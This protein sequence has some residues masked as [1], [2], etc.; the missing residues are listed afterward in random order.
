MTSIKHIINSIKLN[1]PRLWES[2]F[3]LQ[4]CPERLDHHPEGNTFDHTMIVL[5]RAI[6]T[7]NSV[8]IASAIFHDLG[9]LV[10]Y[11]NRGFQ[12]DVEVHSY[13]SHEYAS[14]GFVYTHRAFIDKFFNIYARDVEKIVRNHMRIKSYLDGSMKKRS[15]KTE[16]ENLSVFDELKLFAKLDDMSTPFMGVD[17]SLSVK[18]ARQLVQFC[19][20][21][22]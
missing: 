16:L 1:E 18:Q 22:T 19:K 11:Q 7:E 10:T 20:N 15:K 6:V 2:L 12:G 8:L 9:K 17:D 14:L 21:G 4:Y 13:P 3:E 5:G